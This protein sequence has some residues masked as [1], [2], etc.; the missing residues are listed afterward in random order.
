MKKSSYTLVASLI[1][2][3]ML[4]LGDTVKALEAGGIDAIHFDVMDGVFVPRYGL[5]PEVVAAV[6]SVSSLPVDVHM[7]VEDVEPYIDVFAKAGAHRLVAHAEPHRHLHRTIQKIK[8]AGLEAGVA[9][10][11]ATPLTVLDHVLDDI[12]LVMLMAINPGVVGHPLI[13]GMLNK[14][15]ALKAKLGDRPMEIEIDGGVTPESAPRMIRC[16]ATR[17]VCGTGTIFRPH[18]APL[19]VKIQELKALLDRDV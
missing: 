15:S 11:P 9:L 17:L 16:G 12:S 5:P 13:P 2:A 14:I 3:D 18:E 4:H 1:C 8:A 7:M 19:E 10:N 6:R